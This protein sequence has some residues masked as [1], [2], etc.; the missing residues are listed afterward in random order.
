MPAALLRGGG[1]PLAGGRGLPL[2]C[3]EDPGQS[4]Q[5]PV[6]QRLDRADTAAGEGGD[7]VDREV[8]HETERHDLAL[9]GGQPA[10]SP[11]ELRIER[12]GRER[13]GPIGDGAAVG[14]RAPDRL[15]AGIDDAV[16]GDREHPSPQGGIVAPEPRQVPHDVHEDLAEEVLGIGD[17]L[18]AHIAEHGRRQGLIHLGGV[19]FGFAAGTATP[20]PK[21][22]DPSPDAADVTVVLEPPDPGVAVVVVGSLCD[23]GPGAVVDVVVVVAVVAVV[24]GL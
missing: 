22:H 3:F 13:C 9:L 6:L 1:F 11:D 19:A 10:E 12:V 7:R 5:P 4:V 14:H 20:G 24:D 16:V 23:P 17:I 21:D 15:P 18:A 2:L 8:G